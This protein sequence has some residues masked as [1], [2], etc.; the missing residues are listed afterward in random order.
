MQYVWLYV[1]MWLKYESWVYV[2]CCVAFLSL[3]FLYTYMYMV[4]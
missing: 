2:V 1:K 4:I 3:F